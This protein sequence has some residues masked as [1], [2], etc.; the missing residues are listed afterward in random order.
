MKRIRTCVCG[1]VFEYEIGRGRDRKN[2]SDKCAEDVFKKKQLA[3]KDSLPECKTPGCS[4]KANRKG[5]GL[6]EACYYR[7]RRKGTVH[8]KPLPLY[9]YRYN[10]SAG[11]VWVR[12]PNHPLADSKGL[13]YEHR[14]VFY[15]RNGSGPFKCHW[16]QADINWDVMHVDHLDD[17]KTNN[18]IDNLVPSCPRCNQKRGEWKMVA[19]Q[20]ANGKQITYN[21]VT[22]TAGLWAK[23]LGLSRSAF[24][25]RMEC[26]PIDVVMTMPHGKT[27]PKKARCHDIKSAEEEKGRGR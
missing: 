25:R 20:R 26:W 11:Y 3:N 2:C 22:K 10:Q 14:F 6:C 12:E 27:G 4:N 23:D 1:K 16:C 7:I 18:N 17:D 24:I 8:Y 13:V 9:R 21:G 15:E 5:A 19:K